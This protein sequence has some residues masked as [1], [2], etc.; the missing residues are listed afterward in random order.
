MIGVLLDLAGAVL[1]GKEAGAQ[2][3]ESDRRKQEAMSKSNR[4]T[5]GAVA[6]IAALG[7]IAAL[8]INKLS[9]DKN[10]GGVRRA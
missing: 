6:G 2:M 4:S 5:A 10:K 1:S 8:G 7:A 9:D 3:E